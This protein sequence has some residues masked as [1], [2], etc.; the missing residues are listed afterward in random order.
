ML[1]LFRLG[2]RLALQRF[3]VLFLFRFGFR[4][5]LQGLW[6]LVLFGL[7]LSGWFL[8]WETSWFLGRGNNGRGARLLGRLTLL[9][10]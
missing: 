6:I 8:C 2:A 7:P 5:A 1:F 3:G 9:L 4:L 10:L